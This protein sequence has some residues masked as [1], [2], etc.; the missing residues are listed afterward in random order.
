MRLLAGSVIAERY[1]IEGDVGAGL[2]RAAFLCALA[3]RDAAERCFSRLRAAVAGGAFVTTVDTPA[4]LEG[5]ERYSREDFAGATKAWR[6]LLRSKD[7]RSLG[8]VRALVADAFD[9][10]KEDA[11]VE[12][13]DGAALAAKGAGFRG[14]TLANVRAVKRAARTGN[15]EAAR[16]QAELVVRAWSLADVEIPAVAEMRALAAKGK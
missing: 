11:V 9:R 7:D 10:R 15:T 14:A 4:L 1:E 2:P 8:G 12:A 16:Q 5:A 6:V 13:L 3:S